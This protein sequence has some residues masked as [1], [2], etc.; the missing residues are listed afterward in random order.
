MLFKLF[1]NCIINRIKCADNV[2]SLSI[3]VNALFVMRHLK[4]SN[5]AFLFSKDLSFKKGDSFSI[6]SHSL[7]IFCDI[8]EAILALIHN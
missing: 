6:T 5:V 4:K 8:N 7:T 2:W 3:I 1:V